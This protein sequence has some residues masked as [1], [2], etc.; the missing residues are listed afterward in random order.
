MSVPCLKNKTVTATENSPRT[1]GG[2]SPPAALNNRRPLAIAQIRRV[3][4]PVQKAAPTLPN[5]AAK[6]DH[7]TRP[8]PQP[9]RTQ[10]HAPGRR[11]KLGAPAD[12][13]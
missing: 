11:P 10:Q 1:S 9:L 4:P 5:R 8:F 7:E 12:Q 6:Q 3:R 13:S 2:T